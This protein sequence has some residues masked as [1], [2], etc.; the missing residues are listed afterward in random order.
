MGEAAVI[1]G[2]DVLWIDLDR[3][4]EIRNGSIV[5]FLAGIGGP[6]TMVGNRKCLPQFLT[7]IDNPSAAA[8]YPLD[9]VAGAV[10]PIVC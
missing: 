10:L 2:A 5:L 1:V 8:D 3:Y 7:A 6:T 4:G 9:I